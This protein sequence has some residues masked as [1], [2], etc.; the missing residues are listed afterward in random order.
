M[1]TELRPIRVGIIGSGGI[2]Q[3]RH[4]PG[5]QKLEKT[6]VVAVCDTSDMVA[7]QAAER[8][9][10]PFVFTNYCEMLEKVELDAV[11]VCT[12]NYLHRD[13]TIAALRAGKHVLCEKPLAINARE[14]KEMVEAARKAGKK[15]MVGYNWR[16]QPEAQILKRFT[17]DGKIGEIYYTRVQAL[18]RRGIPGWGVF[19]QKEKQGG[20]CLIDIGVHFLDLA[21]YLMGH[22]QPVSASGLVY[23]KFGKRSDIMGLMGEWERET[24]NVEDFAVGLVRFSNGASLVIETS[25][26]AN[27][28]NDVFNCQI[29]GT[30]GGGQLDPLRIYREEN[31]ILTNITPVIVDTTIPSHFTEIRLFIEAIRKDT[32]VP[33]PGEEA[34]M[35]NRITDAIYRSAELGREVPIE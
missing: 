15:L 11:S 32:A 7:K 13:P 34:L 16:F 33:I 24:F 26:C 17:D 12:P 19:G 3:A 10:I 1:G 9:D 6:E 20:G 8:F 35:V 14:G 30:E 31:R 4:I 21:L 22:P 23:T 2:A 5:Y 28:E 29:F 25:F 27:I 18:R